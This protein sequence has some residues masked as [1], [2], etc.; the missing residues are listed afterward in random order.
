MCGC[1]IILAWSVSAWS[2]L[3]PYFIGFLHGLSVWKIL[4]DWIGI[5]WVEL[6][7]LFGV[8][9][10]KNIFVLLRFPEHYTENAPFCPLS[11]G[12]KQAWKCLKINE[13]HGSDGWHENQFPK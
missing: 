4:V 11:D 7:V 8:I 3:S 10:F 6:W 13:N 5:F 1:G 12:T 9:L 2:V